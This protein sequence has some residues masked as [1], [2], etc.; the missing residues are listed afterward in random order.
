VQSDP[1]ST[2]RVGHGPA[3][4]GAAGS[5]SLIEAERSFEGQKGKDTVALAAT[6]YSE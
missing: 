3:S 2:L 1:V 4:N 5:T 6:N